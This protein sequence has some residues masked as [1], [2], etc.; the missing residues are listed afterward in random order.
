MKRKQL[1]LCLVSLLFFTMQAQIS[2]VHNVKSPKEVFK[3]LTQSRGVSSKQSSVVKQKV[4]KVQVSK[5][6]NVATAGTLKNLLTKAEKNTITHLTIGGIIDARDFKIM[7]DSMF[8]LSVLDINAVNIVTYTGADGTSDYGSNSII[9]PANEIPENAFYVPSDEPGISYSILTSIQLPSSATSIGSIAFAFCN[10][11]VSISIPA[12]ITK[13]GF[14]SFAGCNAKITVD[15]SNPNYSSVDGVL[16]DKAKTKLIQCPVSTAGSY[17]VPVTVSSLEI[18][19]FFLC[20]KLTAVNI[21]SA[22]KSIGIYAFTSCSGS[23]NVDATNPKYTSVDGVLFDKS[24]KKLIQCGTS[25]LG[26]Y[27]IP[28]TVDSLDENSFYNCSLL[29]ALTL[30]SSVR[31]IRDGAFYNCSGLTS[32][33][34]NSLPI[35]L[36]S[37]YNVFYKVNLNTCT[38]NVPFETKPLYQSASVWREFTNIVENPNGFIL[39][40]NKL[41]LPSVAGSNAAIKITS[42]NAWA[43][44]SNQSWLTVSPQNATGNDSITVTAEANPSTNNRTAVITVSAEGVQPQ[45]IEVIQ[46]GIPKTFNLTPG[47]LSTSMT[48][49]EL[50]ATINLK[51]K[52]T[53]DARDFKTMRD[54][55]P[56]LAFLDISEVTIAAYN[57]TGG[58][59]NGTISYGANRIPDYAFNKGFTSQNFTL[60]TISLPTSITSI[61]SNS[62]YSC[63]ALNAILIPNSVTSIGSYAFGSC[64]SLTDVSLSNTLTTIGSQAFE[65]CG[66][67]NI[68]SIPNSVTTIESSAFQ[69]CNSLANLNLGNSLVTIGAGAFFS[70]VKLKSVTI[71]NSV[72]LLQN[73]TFSNCTN[74]DSVRIGNSVTTIGTSCFQNC[75]KLSKVEIPNS[76]SKIEAYAFVSCTNLSTV[77]LGTGVKSIGSYAFS[78]CTGLSSIT[79]NFDIPIDLSLSYGVFANVNFANCVL[80]IPFGTKSAYAAANQWNDFTNIVESTL[81]FRLESNSVK[82]GYNIDSQATIKVTSNNPWN[83]SSDQSWLKISPTTGTGNNSISIIADANSSSLTRTA[84]I[85]VS[86]IGVT[87]KT[88]TVLQAAS[89]KVINIAAG[90]LST[91]L[92]SSELSSISSLTLTGTIDSRD[93]KTM[94]DDMPQLAYLDISAVNILAYNGSLGTIYYNYMNAIP[95]YA[96]CSQSSYV[97]KASLI[98]VILPSSATSIRS[99]SFQSCSGL[100]SISIPNSITEIGYGAFSGCTALMGV[101]LPTQMTKIQSSSF[102]NCTNLKSVI[103]PNSVTTIEYSAFQSCIGLDSIAIPNSVTTMGTNAF[104]SCRNLTKIT[105]PNALTLID[106]GVFSNCT[107][108]QSITIPNSV[109][110]ISS[111][112]ANCS[113]LESIN[114]GSA[115]K[116]IYSGSFESCTSLTKIAIPTTVTY[117]GDNVFR[118]CTALTD[119]S[120]PNSVAYMGSELFSGC[121]ALKEITIPNS[122]NTLNYR[123]FYNCTALN[124]V[125]IASSVKTIDF[126]AFYNCISLASIVLPNSVKTLGSSS[127]ESCTKLS[128][129]VLGDSLT[130]IGGNSFMGCTALKNITLPT[131]LV[132]IDYSAFNGCTGLTSIVLPNSVSTLGNNAFIN[133]SGLV[134]ITLANSLISIETY[135][136]SKCSKLTNVTFGNSLKSIGDMAFESCTSLANITLPVSLKTIGGS[137]FYNCTSLSGIIIPNTVVTIGPWAFQS[138]AGLTNAVLSN[139]MK[140]IDS[141]IFYNCS[142]LTSIDIPNSVISLGT[143]AFWGCSSL[144][145]VTMGNSIT[146]INGGAFN[147]CSKLTS[148]TIP[149]SVTSIGYSAFESC[150]GLKSII[151]NALVPINLTNNHDVFYNVDKNLCTLNVPYHTKPLYKAANQWGDFINIVENPYGLVL[152]TDSLNLSVKAGSNDSILITSN[153]SWTVNSNQ[154]WLKVSSTTGSGNA[155]LKLTAEANSLFSTRKAIVTV[156]ASGIEPQSVIVTQ[157]AATKTVV[158]SAGGLSSTLTHDEHTVLNRLTISGT[159][160]ATDFKFMRDS[161]PNL[162]YLDISQTSINAYTGSN[163]T[164]DYYTTSYPAGTIPQNGFYNS[165]NYAHNNVLKSIL[166]PATISS[167]GNAAFECC[168]KL[169]SIAI[170]N[171]VS[172]IGDYSFGACTNLKNVNIPSSLSILGSAFGGC[173]SLEKIVIPNSVT[174]LSYSTFSNCTGLKSVTLSK[175]LTSIGGYTFYNCTGLTSISIP[176]TVTLIDSYAFNNCSALVSVEIG[177]KVT[178]IG[179]SAFYSCTS[180]TELTLPKS[181][182][183]IGDY[184]FNNCTSLSI[185]TIPESVTSIGSYAFSC[186]SLKSILSAAPIPITL[187]SY[188]VFGAV[189]KSTCT[190]YVPSG[191]KTL[192]Q[193][194]TQW[195]E[196]S[197]ISEDFGFML[198]NDTVRIVS[199]ESV[200]IDIPTTNT[201]T[202]ASNQTW[203]KTSTVAGNGNTQIVLAGDANPEFGLRTALVK[204]SMIDGPSQNITVI[205]SGTPKTVTVSS[206]NLRTS[207]SP[208][209]LKAVSNLILTG[210]I[211][212]RDFRVM[213]DSMPQLA[214]INLKEVSITAY[215]G[216]EGTNPSVSSYPANETPINAF[217][218]TYSGVGK[219]TLA[220]VILPSNTTAIGKSSF[221]Y[222]RG[223]SSIVIPNQVTLIGETA[224]AW[225]EGL[226]DVTIGNSVT[227]IGVEAFWICT[228]LSGVAIPNSVTTISAEAFSNCV[229]L[230]W[231][232]FPNGLKT[233]ASDAFSS[234][235]SLASIDLPNTITTLDDDVFYGCKSMTKANI[236]NSITDLKYGLFYS[237][238]SLKEITIPASVKTIGPR[239]FGRCSSLTTI[240]IPAT[241]TKMDYG[242]FEN[243]TGLTSIYAY[244]TMPIDLS[245]SYYALVFNNV[246]KTTCKLYVPTGTKALYAAAIEWKDFTNIIEM[247]TALPKLTNSG[248]SIYPNPVKDFFRIEGLTE[249]ADVSIVDL[250]GKLVLNQQITVNDKVSISNLTNGM[251]IVRIISSM[252]YVECKLLKK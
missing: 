131:T 175:S 61:G 189:N 160:D 94:R 79:V 54:N 174:S 60:T 242:V 126:N 229:A 38:L 66:K 85:T 50:S 90:G 219:L 62:F 191:S 24:V 76:V 109:V 251:Y 202:V 171:S 117:I 246:N 217:Y 172:S 95:D 141:S 133:C 63:E 93:F 25:K 168:Y 57:G 154:S 148:I 20:N 81:G 112:F 158:V 249:N 16:F 49:A 10:E 65:S 178:S 28:A 77:L 252:G 51:I 238:S 159:L 214:D 84:T 6:L 125:N 100:T 211:D 36:S 245:A 108:L 71:P 102:Q 197:K 78:G 130:T 15:E 180:L 194:A 75:S 127:F 43:V 143:N 37:T 18:Y 155:N 88:I 210:T 250:N 31:S 97:G 181:V 193:A 204:F 228:K 33:T 161:I 11:L 118:N 139:S 142:G 169:D 166:L 116:S 89:P 101:I 179:M 87:S 74:L 243:C 221:A 45:T 165:N 198:S 56:K 21:P 206:G 46:S 123:T 208:E 22:V 187:S 19:S 240:S 114:F 195:Q 151:A 218:K 106:G 231:V 138:C 185:I 241:V 136:F 92:T 232:T 223:L 107:S 67:L 157:D 132:K 203:L 113:K 122:I 200:N 247:T 147:G 188:A 29:T 128:D 209:E 156:Q 121:T 248:I 236:P 32:F 170:P 104:A 239:V 153:T 69:D 80:S 230:K 144:A 48:A 17:D 192:Y 96:F 23:I 53:I 173:I 86:A 222:A 9:Y 3:F 35:S 216:A 149:G 55:M 30:P 163:G 42:I 105:L 226:K 124:K 233:L 190:L 59:S 91:A 212:A 207:L 182:Q 152:N 176:N 150:T 26:S 14:V 72:I 98:S 111:A 234:C 115:I 70:C 215:S 120:I 205:Q 82:L 39:G 2:T 199:G 103:I 1:L 12:K 47:G 135:T 13:I 41:I 213:R 146:T 167:I 27:I 64:S 110:T 162:A 177:N 73:N 237:C 4:R 201:F 164:V 184:A 99:S 186:S 44:S 140:I 137:A 58:T 40:T 225:C 220:S 129:V 235:R 7:R 134:S 183:T 196:F 83:V 8:S 224:F 244:Q 145:N 52:G 119:V 227:T 5:T 68:I 34:V